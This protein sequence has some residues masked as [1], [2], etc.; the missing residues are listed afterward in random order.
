MYGIKYVYTSQ[1]S[2]SAIDNIP[3]PVR[4]S[5]DDNVLQWSHVFQPS[6]LAP[7]FQ[8]VHQFT[9]SYLVHMTDRDDVEAGRSMTRN[10]TSLNIE[11]MLDTCK[12]QYFTVQAVIDNETLSE[13]SSPVSGFS[14][15]FCESL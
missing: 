10:E 14:G 7:D 4:V 15:K 11:D 3:S 5:L 2:Y 1:S 13:N 12:R 8:L 9:L 6:D